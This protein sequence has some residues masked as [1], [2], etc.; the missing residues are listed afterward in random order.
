MAEISLEPHRRALTLLL[1]AD[2]TNGS[3]LLRQLQAGELQPEVALLDASLVPGVFPVLAA[4]HKA[5]LA[6]DRGA[7]RTRTL[8]SEIV[9]N[10]AAS[11]H[12]RD[13]LQRLGVNTRTTDVLVGCCDCTPAEVASIREL[14]HGRE[15]PLSELVARCDTDAVRKLYKITEAELEASSLEDCVVCRIA[16]RDSLT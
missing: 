13:S 6:Q 5:V 15:L 12:I 8:H 2:V 10:Y 1:F 14:V 4:A 11:K 7:L 9:Y 16:A 3:E